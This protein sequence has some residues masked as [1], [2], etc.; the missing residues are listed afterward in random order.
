VGLID[1]AVRNTVVSRRVEGKLNAVDR[2][3]KR[4]LKFR[5]SRGRA[6]KK[7]LSWGRARNG[8]IVPAIL[9]IREEFA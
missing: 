1:G 9:D 4:T 3:V 7:N 5:T 2:R 6:R 8:E